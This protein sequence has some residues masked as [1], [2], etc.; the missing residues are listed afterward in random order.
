MPFR[1]SYSVP[2]FQIV[3]A[4]HLGWFPPQGWGDSVNEEVLPIAAYALGLAGI[5][6]EVVSFLLAS[7]QTSQDYIRTARAKGLRQSIIVWIH[8]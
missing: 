4:L 8:A 5:L 6:G 3:F 1:H 7:K 2:I